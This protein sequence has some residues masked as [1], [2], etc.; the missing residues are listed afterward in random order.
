MRMHKMH[1]LKADLN[2]EPLMGN[3]KDLHNFLAFLL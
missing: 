3:Y 1:T 2:N